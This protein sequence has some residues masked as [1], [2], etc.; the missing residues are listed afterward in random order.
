MLASETANS[1]FHGTRLDSE[2]IRGVMERLIATAE[3]R[4]GVD[5]AEVAAET[6]FV[7]HETYTPARGGSAQAEVDALR[8]VFGGNAAKVVIANTKGFTGHAMGAGVEDVLAVKSLETGIVPP[9]PNHKEIDPDLG[10]LTL[11]RGGSYPVRYSL[12]LGAGFGSQ[13]AMTLYRA[14]TS[15]NGHTAPDQL[16]YRSR[17]A[18]PRR[19]GPGGCPPSQGLPIPHRS[20]TTACCASA[21]TGPRS[22]SLWSPRCL[23]IVRIAP[24]AAVAEAGPAL[25]AVAPPVTPPVAPPVVPPAAPAPAPEASDARGGDRR[26]GSGGGCG[27]GGGGGADRVSDGHVGPGSGS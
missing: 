21:T 14:V 3:G 23:Q 26:G 6:V 16:G 1:A 8:H 15:P 19:R 10:P 22:A 4:W 7:S 24:G 17:I 20:P 2:H 12:R 11:S 9:V 18:D 27:A 5:R 13:V 25:P